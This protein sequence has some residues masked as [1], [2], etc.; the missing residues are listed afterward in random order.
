MRATE[1]DL[2]GDCVQGTNC[3][4]QCCRGD[5]RGVETRRKKGSENPKGKGSRP[6]SSPQRNS[7]ERGSP[8]KNISGKENQPTCFNFLRVVVQKEMIV[9]TAST[10]VF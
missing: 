10:C 4:G 8:T 9:I 1:L 7:L 3:K 6:S 2:S 5:R